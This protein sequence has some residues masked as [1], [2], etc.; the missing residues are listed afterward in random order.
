MNA[1]MRTTTW[2]KTVATSIR[3]RLADPRRDRGDNTLELVIVAPVLLLA[4]G[5]MIV[6]GIIAQAHMKVQHA[7]AEAARAASLARTAMQAQPSA[8][9]AALDDLAAKGL[10][11][12]SVAT[13]VDTSA[14][15]TRPGVE[16]MISATVSCT[17]SFDI[18]GIP[19]ISGTRT[20]EHTESSPLD[21]YRERLR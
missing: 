18:L 2:V 21:S 7:A 9:T 13:S 3:A 15:R 4:I 6:A 11:C 5:L 16:S 10:T 17:I 1:T 14:F 19:G 20:V 8:A 12:T